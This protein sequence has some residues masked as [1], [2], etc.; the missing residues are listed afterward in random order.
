MKTYIRLFT[1]F[2]L[3]LISTSIY[4][5]DKAVSMQKEGDVR[6]FYDKLIQVEV[7]SITLRPV[8][9][10]RITHCDNPGDDCIIGP[11]I[12]APCR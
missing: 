5:P 8:K 3:I 10:R 1:I 4:A 6:L 7:N 11:T 2:I 12:K 9:Y